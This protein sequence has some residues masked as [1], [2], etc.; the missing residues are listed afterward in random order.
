MFIKRDAEKLRE[1]A[2]YFE[3]IVVNGPRQSGKTTMLRDLF[4]DYY[5]Y[6]LENPSTLRIIES[7]PQV[8]VNEKCN[9]IIII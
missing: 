4:H 2:K 3:V 6:N 9:N 5:Y 7:D 8:F 1:Y